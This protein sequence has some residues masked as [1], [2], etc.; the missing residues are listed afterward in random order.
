MNG[1][2][3]ARSSCLFFFHCR[4]FLGQP[5]LA[6]ARQEATAQI[7]KSSSDNC[8]VSVGSEALGKLMGPA[9]VPAVDWCGSDRRGLFALRKVL[10]VTKKKVSRCSNV[11]APRA[12]ASRRPLRSYMVIHTY[13]HGHDKNKTYCYMWT[14]TLICG[15]DFSKIMTT[16]I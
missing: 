3:W 16:R 15:A 11:M 14:C 7:H 13:C 5:H 2:S 10:D 9:T 6:M 4:R 1:T 12:V 8:H